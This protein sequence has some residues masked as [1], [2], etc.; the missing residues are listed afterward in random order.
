MRPFG[1][2]L[3]AAL[4][5]ALMAPAVAMA[6]KAPA[7]AV[8]PEARKVGMADAPALVAAA[9][10]PCKVTDARLV[11]KAPP[12]KKTGSLGSSLYEVACEGAPGFLSGLPGRTIAPVSGG[13]GLDRGRLY[14]QR[15]VERRDRDA[16]TAAVPGVAAF[17]AAAAAR[18]TTAAE[19]ISVVPVS[20]AAALRRSACGTGPAC[21]GRPP[22]RG[23]LT[24]GLSARAVRG[25]RSSVCAVSAGAGALHA[26][27]A[28]GH[29]ADGR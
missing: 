23:E 2:G 17:A 1:L 25:C 26:G 16:G 5:V 29:P 10:L 8:S 24:I 22:L 3:L 7:S 14:A 12:D 21:G 15:R 20:A 11:G 13:A 6:A 4:I 27:Q 18:A 9:S 19:A 28:A